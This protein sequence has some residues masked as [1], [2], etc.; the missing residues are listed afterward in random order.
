MQILY[1]CTFYHRA[2]I[3]RDSMN[4]LEGLGHKVTAYNAVAKGTPIDEKFLPIMDEK[5]IHKECF[6]NI[7]R[8]FF[9]LQTKENMQSR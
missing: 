5:V 8:Y 9:L 4:Y 3:F 2:M 1:M 7:D 6:R